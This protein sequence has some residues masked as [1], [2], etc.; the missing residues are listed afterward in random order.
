MFWNIFKFKLNNRKILT[1]KFV[2]TICEQ[3]PVMNK[4]NE[5]K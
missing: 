4:T 1:L 5:K 2:L 3:Y